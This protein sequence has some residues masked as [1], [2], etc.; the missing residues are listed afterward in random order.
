MAISTITNILTSSSIGKIIIG[1]Y[2]NST[3]LPNNTATK[4]GSI[5]LSRGAWIIVAC[6]DWEVNATGYRQI[7]FSSGIN[8][9]RKLATTT[10][11]LSSKEVYQQLVSL[12]TF[13]TDTTT[14][15]Y[16]VQN[17][18]AALNIYPYVYAIK[19]GIT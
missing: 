18:G 7:A 11:G 15:L 6:A 16:A 1:T 2:D 14:N 17:S 13:D 5:E 9:T 10:T 12:F 3:S 4:V 19:I 8:P